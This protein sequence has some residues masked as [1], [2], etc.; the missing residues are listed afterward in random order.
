MGTLPAIINRTIK[1]IRSCIKVQLLTAA[2][3]LPVLIAWGLPISIMSIV[4]NLVALPFL[5]LTLF[6]CS[7]LFLT[8]LINIPNG[9]LSFLCEQVISLWHYLLSLGSPSWLIGFQAPSLLFSIVLMSLLS[10]G[11]WYAVHRYKIR[12]E[13]ASVSGIALCI[14]ASYFFQNN[15]IHSIERI[16]CINRTN[17]KT[18]IDDGFFRFKTSYRSPVR[19]QI[20]PLLYKVFGSNHIHRWHCIYAGVRSLRALQEILNEISI[21][22]ISFGYFPKKQTPAWLQAWKE[23]NLKAEGCKTTILYATGPRNT[24]AKN[25]SSE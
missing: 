3:S 13:I 1:I 18:V 10:I 25:V 5:M 7:V 4:G 8:E 11:L 21:D 19:Y 23:L 20:K 17:K 12:I 14:F 15:Q 9:W 16:H 22:E 2:L 6:L 24:D